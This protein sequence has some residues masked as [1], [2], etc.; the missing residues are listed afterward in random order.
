MKYINTKTG[1][2]IDV[3]SEIKGGDWMKVQSP[4]IF[5][6]EA[7]PEVKEDTPKKRTKKS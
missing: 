5:A 3:A 6:D 4:S 2:I 1:S 7:K